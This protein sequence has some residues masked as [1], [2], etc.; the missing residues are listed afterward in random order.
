MRTL[1][2]I[3]LKK[4]KGAFLSTSSTIAWLLGIFGTWG[5]VLPLGHESKNNGNKKRQFLKDAEEVI[6]KYRSADNF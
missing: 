5:K 4:K 1:R 6:D 2:G 3:A